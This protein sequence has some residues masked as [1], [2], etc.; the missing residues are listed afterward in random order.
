M[1]RRRPGL[2]RISKRNEEKEREKKKKQKKKIKVKNT[3]YIDMRQTAEFDDDDDDDGIYS[4]KCFP[5]FFRSLFQK[6][7]SLLFL[8]L[9]FVR[10]FYQSNGCVKI[11]K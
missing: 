1:L 4:P 5:S 8:F 10:K 11:K 7:S 3:L 6:F 2:S 9:N